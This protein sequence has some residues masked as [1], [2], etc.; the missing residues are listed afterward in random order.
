[1]RYPSR[2]AAET[3]VCLAENGVDHQVFAKLM[4]EGLDTL[5]NGLTNWEGEMGMARLWLNVARVGAVMNSRRARERRGE[6]R[7]RGFRDHAEDDS[8]DEDEDPDALRIDPAIQQKSTAWWADQIS[9]CPSS[10]EETVMVLLDSG[11]TPL[12]CPVLAEKLK[13]VILR[14]IRSYVLRYKIEIPMSCTAFI[15]PGKDISYHNHAYI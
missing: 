3:I 14:A 5:V 13:H 8:D 12:D 7:S 6:S 15:I 2:L 10:L 9:G 4:T 11:F 1:M